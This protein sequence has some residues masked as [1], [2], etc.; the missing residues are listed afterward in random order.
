VSSLFSAT[1]VGVMIHEGVSKL[2]QTS[3]IEK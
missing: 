1:S 2:F 3:A